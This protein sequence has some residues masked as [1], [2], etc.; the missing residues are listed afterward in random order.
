MIC[1]VNTSFPVISAREQLTDMFDDADNS[2]MMAAKHKL[3]I[4]RSFQARLRTNHP[5]ANL[6]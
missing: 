6:G 3:V 4:I 1:Q 2:V 5:A